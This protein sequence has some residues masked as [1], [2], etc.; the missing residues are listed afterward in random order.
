LADLLKGMICHVNLIP[1]NAV[2]ETTYRRS[3]QE[4]IARFLQVLEQNHVN[5]TVRRELGSDI[6][7]ACGQLRSDT[8]TQEEATQR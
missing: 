4:G 6:A 1:V 3:K 8:M 7:A 2:K 5:A